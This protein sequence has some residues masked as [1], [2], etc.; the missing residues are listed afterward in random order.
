MTLLNKWK[1]VLDF[2]KVENRERAAKLLD[3]NEKRFN[4]DPHLILKLCQDAD[5]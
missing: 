5:R 3:Q 4:K 1:P 2:F